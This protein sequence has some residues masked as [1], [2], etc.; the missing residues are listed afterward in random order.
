MAEIQ[1]TRGKVRFEG[2][3]IFDR[4]AQGTYREGI[5]KNGEGRPY[6]S[7][8]LGV[9]TSKTN[10]VY[11]IDLF[12]QIPADKNKVA[13]ISKFKGK[14]REKVEVNY[15]NKKDIPDGVAVF[16][17]GIVGVGHDGKTVKN[18]FTYDAIEE[19]CNRYKSGDPVWIDATF[20]IDTYESNGETR[21]TIKYEIT[22]IGFLSEALDFDAEDFKEISSYEQ[23]VVVVDHVHVP[24]TNKLNVAVR[25]IHWDGTWKDATF[26]IDMSTHKDLAVNVKKKTKFGDIL[27]IRGVVVNA[28]VLTETEQPTEIDWGG[29]DP[30]GQGKRVIK[31]HISEVRITNVVSHEAKKYKEDDFIVPVS[32]TDQFDTSSSKDPFKD[33]EPDDKDP[34]KD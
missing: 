19:I 34:F 12:G 13:K 23:D 4:N 33:D 14:T 26:V 30:E 17:F 11:N 6:R 24:E 16:G 1:Q 7:V 5:T 9:K 22:K 32:T 18:Y 25:I 31:D 15:N 29:T 21:T 10:K 28:V 3:L 8:S 2:E 27:K 20:K